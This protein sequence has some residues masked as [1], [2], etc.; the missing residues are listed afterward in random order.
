LVITLVMS[1]LAVGASLAPAASA[2]PGPV[3]PRAASTV[4][5]DA[6][7]TVQINGVA[8]SQAVVG[9]TVYAGG[10]FSTARPAGAAPGVSTTT[11]N[12]LLSYNLTTGVLNSFAPSLNAQ[13]QV[14][15]ASPDGSRIYVGGDFTS[16]S[17]VARNRIAAFSTST[18]ALLSTFNAS[19]NGRVKAIA[20]TNNTVY[21]GGSFTTAAGATRTRLA[22]FSASTGALTA[23]NPGADSTV[24]AMVLTPDSSRVIVGGAFQHLG[25]GG[26]AA[27]GLGA[28]DS[29][30]GA[31]L[32]WAA[33]Q[34][35]RDAGPNS[36]ILSLS[37][38][39]TAVYG[40]GYVFGSGGNLEGA[41]SANP[42]TG[43]LNWVEDCHGDSYSVF[44]TGQ[45]VYTVS[46]AHYCANVGGFYQSE[47]WST[48]MR[49]AIAFTPNATGTVDTNPL[50]GYFDWA[51]NPSPSI[52]DWFP[53]MNNGTFTGQ[54]QAA[55]SITGNSQYVVMGG[56]FPRVNDVGQQ[57]LVRFA[58]KPIAPA[59]RGPVLTGSRF[60]PTLLQT[61]AHS[62]KVSFGTNWDQDDKTLYY[63]VVRDGNVGAP[64]HTFTADS[65]FWN[66]PRLG[67]TDQLPAGEPA[68]TT[69]SYRLYVNDV[70]GGGN[71]VIG[72]SVSITMASA[73]N[74][75]SY[76]SA[77]KSQGAST[78]WR[79]GESS[80]ATAVD[81]AGSNDGA[82]TGG[83]SRG[84]TGAIVGDT[85]RATV[86]NGS[87][88]L[89][90]TQ[91]PIPGPNTFSI[92]AWFKTTTTSGGKIIGFGNIPVGVSAFADRHIYMDN[93]GHLIFGV[94]NGA[95]RT[96]Q[97]A[98]TYNNGQ[99]HQVVGTLGP[100]GMNF[101]VDGTRVAT[102]TDVVSGR[103]RS[104]FWRVGGDIL[105]GW[106]SAPTS[107]YFNGT[108][109]EVS[110]YDKVL[111]AAEVSTQYQLATTG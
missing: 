46:H 92:E 28:V 10:N 111:T 31:L 56:E 61:G 30:T 88:G 42:N 76:A 65:L 52:M 8:W 25:V 63:R 98:G 22:A 50:P 40:T 78:Y 21:V 107:K 67:F 84:A 12:N 73:V 4:T 62:V 20:A 14:V 72:D 91:N 95:A 74:L 87:S 5:A 100:D 68:G 90:A 79:L 17:G 60:V 1:G 6:L 43:T 32:P 80:G 45:T 85:N 108:I 69:H 64:V 37:T 81:W 82:V 26:G 59:K 34:K 53:T 101:Y 29:G 11:R 103:A 110:I 35:V 97:T 51:G 7:P 2:A 83:V 89:V 57:G 36:A 49:H 38:D 96:Q 66:R 39:G 3:V 70:S 106:P 44:S 105:N 93:A 27:Y 18:G 77:V 41:F 109:D 47:P 94:Q 24:N 23:W 86:F 9:N 104:G 75:S 54:N 13:A 55:W 48:N 15:A 99:W 102:R 71:Q 19:V 16:I 58:V 33:N